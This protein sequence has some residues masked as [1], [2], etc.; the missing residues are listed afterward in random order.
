MLLVEL[1]HERKV[2]FIAPGRDKPFF[3]CFRDI[4]ARLIAMG[5]IGKFAV[6]ADIHYF[7]KAFPHL[8]S[9]KIPYAETF[10][11]RSVDA[12]TPESRRKKLG[13]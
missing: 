3:D 12:K 2:R 9:R 4:A 5:A 13:I 6:M 10:N 8:L 11:T 1:I 7:G